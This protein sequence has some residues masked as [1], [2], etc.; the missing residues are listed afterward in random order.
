MNNTEIHLRFTTSNCFLS[1]L[2]FIFLQKLRFLFLR[3]NIICYKNIANIGILC[4][5][6]CQIKADHST[7]QEKAKTFHSFSRGQCMI[8]FWE[9]MPSGD[10]NRTWNDVGMTFFDNITG[11]GTPSWHSGVLGDSICTMYSHPDPLKVIGWV[12]LWC[13]I[14][15]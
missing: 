8:S 5:S 10:F 4:Q 6:R 13:P 3:G 2:W 1:R 11:L 14:R 7:E 12:G 9:R 15:F